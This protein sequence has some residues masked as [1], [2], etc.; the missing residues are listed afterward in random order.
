MAVVALAR[1][2]AGPLQLAVL[3]CDD[4]LLW[5]A[6]VLCRPPLKC[7]ERGLWRARVGWPAGQPLPEDVTA[8][9][10]VHTVVHLLSAADRAVVANECPRQFFLLSVPGGTLELLRHTPGVKKD[11]Q[12]EGQA[13]TL[14][15]L[16]LCRAAVAA[17]GVPPGPAPCSTQSLAP[18]PTTMYSYLMVAVARFGGDAGRGLGW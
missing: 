3:Q 1:A 11:W 8:S 2:Q 7:T 5:V 6:P 17:L 14:E 18:T 16:R 4:G 15:Q 13:A 10:P 12:G 9:I